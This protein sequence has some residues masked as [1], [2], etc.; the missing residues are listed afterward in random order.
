MEQERVRTGLTSAE[1]KSRLETYGPNKLARKQP[2]SALKLLFSQFASPLIYV[3]F[4]AALVT[5]FLGDFADAAVIL[6]AV[7]VNTALGFY[8]EYKA[9]KGL[10]ALK[11]MLEPKTEVIR[12]GRRQEVLVEALVPG[13]V[14]LLSMGV[15]VPADGIWLK[16]KDVTVNEAI[17]TGESQSVAKK[18]I[19]QTTWQ[20]ISDEGKV[21]SD[22]DS[23]H[24]AFMGTDV[25]SGLGRMMI[26]NTGEATK[27][28]QIAQSL[29]TQEEEQTPLQK[30][31]ADFSRWLAI[32]VGIVSFVLLIVGLIS[33][34]PFVEIFPTAVAV[35]VS[36]IPEGL[37][38]ALTAI[39]ALGMQRILK[40]Q[41]LVR[42]LVAAET[43]GSVTVICADKTGTLTE[44]KMRVVKAD[45]VDHQLGVL[46]TLLCNDLRDPLEVAMA[47]WGKNNL[48]SQISNLKNQMLIPLFIW[49]W[50]SRFSIGKMSARVSKT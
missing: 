2:F 32:L 25:V 46:G 50:V 3:L 28:G 26:I 35:A 30:K 14:V 21:A 1:T 34:T 15:R 45:F 39:L 10:E 23:D 31:L 37:V 48:K 40:R 38:V 41:A 42:K 24:W 13:D 7:A 22:L 6:L 44:G 17:L 5:V 9:A 16:A 47:E 11:A 29:A 19:R 27:M 4:F 43:L 8:Q 49:A 18:A 12:D 20:H 36:A 33:G